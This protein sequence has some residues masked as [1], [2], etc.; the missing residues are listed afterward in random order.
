MN[1]KIFESAWKENKSDGTFSM[2]VMPYAKDKINKHINKVNKLEKKLKMMEIAFEQ[3]NNSRNDLMRQLSNT[4]K[5][6]ED[7]IEY[8]ETVVSVYEPKLV[9]ILRGEYEP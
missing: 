5:I 4:E 2:T 7:A 3:I 9:R 8:S 6:I 1:I